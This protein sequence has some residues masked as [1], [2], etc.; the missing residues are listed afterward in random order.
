MV[1]YAEIVFKELGDPEARRGELRAMFAGVAGLRV[2]QSHERFH[3]VG[4]E[5]QLG[6]VR[7]AA[8]GL[9]EATVTYQGPTKKTPQPMYEQSASTAF[10]VPWAFKPY[11]W[12]GR[13]GSVNTG[14]YGIVNAAEPGEEE[15]WVPKT[16]VPKFRYVEARSALSEADDE[17]EAP[18]RRRKAG[19]VAELLQEMEAALPKAQA[20]SGYGQTGS[21]L[22]RAHPEVAAGLRLYGVSPEALARD[23]RSSGAYLAQA[24]AIIALANRGSLERRELES[25][26]ARP[27]EEK[28]VMPR[29][30]EVMESLAESGFVAL[31]CAGR[32]RYEFRKDGPWKGR[33]EE[34]R[35]VRETRKA[36]EDWY[37][38][39]VDILAENPARRRKSV[40]TAAIPKAVVEAAPVEARDE[41]PEAPRG[42][43]AEAASAAPAPA[44]T[45]APMEASAES[46]ARASAPVAAAPAAD[47]WSERG[48]RAKEELDAFL[49][50]G[51]REALSG[52]AEAAYLRRAGVLAALSGSNGRWRT[53]LDVRWDAEALVGAF[54][55]DSA[56]AYETTDIVS[57]LRAL[58]KG[59]RVARKGNRYRL[60]PLTASLSGS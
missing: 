12:V 45:S 29:W 40:L 26:L 60:R 58:E 41:S 55:G 5:G 19:T 15:R 4:K 24:L 20:G 23:T 39:L 37:D 28:G 16:F 34:A 43:E 14:R 25:L 44:A 7:A 32:R 13:D 56:V 8:A 59:E 11:R 35:T 18:R 3:I 49:N 1:R 10:G 51:E 57:D 46:A 50:E 17:D 27:L 48:L 30:N 33:Y 2:Y 42:A 38:S 36:R 6:A 9:K 22:V 54:L 21:P 52:H 47:G 31:P 53:P